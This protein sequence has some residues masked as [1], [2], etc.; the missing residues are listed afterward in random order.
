MNGKGGAILD[1]DTAKLAKGPAF[2]KAEHLQAH[3][4]NETFAQGACT[5]GK[6]RFGQLLIERLVADLGAP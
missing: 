2:G 6:L 5:L 1:Q 4:A 3:V